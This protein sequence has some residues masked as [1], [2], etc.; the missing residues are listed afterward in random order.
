MGEGVIADRKQLM[1]TKGTHTAARIKLRSIKAKES[2][3]CGKMSG[4]GLTIHLN[5]RSRQNTVLVNHII[6]MDGFKVP[7]LPLAGAVKRKYPTASVEEESRGMLWL[8]G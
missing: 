7:A 8:V 4:S 1:M 2:E 3:V 5:M 6:I